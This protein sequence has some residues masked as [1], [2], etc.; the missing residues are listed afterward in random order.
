MPPILDLKL[1]T[2]AGSLFWEDGCRNGCRQV[3]EG[4]RGALGL[5][6]LDALLGGR[7]QR[8]AKQLLEQNLRQGFYSRRRLAGWPTL[9]YHLADEASVSQV[10]NGPVSI[11]S[12]SLMQVRPSK[13]TTRPVA[14]PC[15]VVGDELIVIYGSVCFIQ[16][17]G[18][19]GAAIVSQA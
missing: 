4:S 16:G 1:T 17:I 13:E 19:S 5:V 10:A 2:T 14:F 18:A 7:N 12:L 11:I 8:L 3:S 15:L 9:R 6:G